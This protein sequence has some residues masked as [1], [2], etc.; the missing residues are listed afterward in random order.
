MSALVLTLREHAPERLDM[1][2]VVPDKLNAMS[3]GDIAALILPAGKANRRLDECFELSGDVASDLVLSGATDRLDYIGAGL[4]SG[5]ITV[6]GGAGDFLAN[7]MRGGEIHVRGDVGA[8]TASGMRA[9][10]VRVEGNVGDFLG[11]PIPGARHGLRGGTVLVHGD[12]GDRAGERQRRG[13]ILIKGNAGDYLGARM[14]AGTIVVLGQAGRHCG[15]AMRRGTLL[16]AGPPASLPPTFNESGRH[17]LEFLKLFTLSW[18]DL[19]SG[20][21]ELAASSA[22]V[23]RFVGDRACAGKGEVLVRM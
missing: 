5:R 18:R 19:G 23:R 8:Y 16:L 17:Q 7:D 3:P 15:F 13:Q 11:G 2:G 1:R 20:F 6:D 10:L 12:A 21:T 9:G 4:S 14:L 22:G